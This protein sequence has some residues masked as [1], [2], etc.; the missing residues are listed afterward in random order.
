MHKT[1][2]FY[3]VYATVSRSSLLL[4]Q[5]LPHY[6][7][8]TVELFEQCELPKSRSLWRLFNLSV[9]VQTNQYITVKSPAEKPFVICASAVMPTKW[10]C[11]SVYTL[12][13]IIIQICI[14]G[15]TTRRNDLVNYSQIAP[16][17][18]RLFTY[19]SGSDVG[20]LGVRFIIYLFVCL[21]IYYFLLLCWG[22]KRNI[23]VFIIPLFL[24]FKDQIT[25]LVGKCNRPWLFQEKS[26]FHYSWN[27]KAIIPS[28]HGKKAIIPLFH[29]KNFPLFLF[30]FIPRFSTIGC[31]WCYF[32]IDL[33]ITL[34]TLFQHLNFIGHLE[35]KSWNPKADFAV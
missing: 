31:C 35:G 5:P 16:I 14:A 29:I 4:I 6:C 20:Y 15:K 10:Y 3:T 33:I 9:L 21:F 26:L 25:L 2:V 18:D 22:M 28:F 1:F 7:V 34:L 17:S 27:T 30:V 8:A 32:H 11:S 19:L 12:R 23:W 24:L 13:I